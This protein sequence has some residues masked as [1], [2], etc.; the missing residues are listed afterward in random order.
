[1]VVEIDRNDPE[2]LAAYFNAETAQIGWSELER[3]YAQGVV[4]YVAPSLDLVDVAVKLAQDDSATFSA[5]MEQSLVGRMGDDVAAR[6]YD[7]KTEVWAVVAAPW[8]LVQE[9]KLQG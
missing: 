1:V 8:V 2:Q 9:N 7:S 5:W 6:L 4:L 3:F